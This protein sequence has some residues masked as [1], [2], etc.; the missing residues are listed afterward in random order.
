MDAKYDLSTYKYDIPRE[1]IAQK[2]LP[3]RDASRLLILDKKSGSITHEK[4]FKIHDY[5]NPGDCIVI[6]D[7]KV[8]PARLYGVKD[9]TDAQIELLFLE[10]KSEYDWEVMIKNSRRVRP[11]D[12]I[13]LPENIKAVILEKSGKISRVRLNF[14]EEILK[15]KLWKS[16]SMPLPPY[17]KQDIHNKI[18]KE[19][20]QTV[21]AAKEGAVAAPTAGLHF[22]EK[23]FENLRS[24]GVDVVKI[25]LHVGIGTFKPVVAKDIRQHR[26]H[27][28]YFEISES[29]AEII[30]KAKRVIACGTT[31]LRCLESAVSG[32]KIMPKSGYTDIF[33]YP[34]YEFKIVNGLIT[35]FHQPESTLL[36][37]VCAFAGIDNIRHAYNEAIKNNYRFYS[38][39]DAM[40]IK[41]D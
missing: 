1:L 2:P 23:V 12:T 30:N 13:I 37:L 35:N 19:R 33:I 26:M 11:G 36:M 20:Y 14:T 6:N 22:T 7:T 4:F 25:T 31:S 39:G 38:Y 40:F 32:S 28:E 21:F 29:S 9:K 34:G 41:G 16:G 24:K 5:L 18:H 10:K 3:S 8:F 15:D 27:R 17:I